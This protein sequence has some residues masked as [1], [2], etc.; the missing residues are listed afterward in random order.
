[1][2][3]QRCGSTQF[4]FD[5]DYEVMYCKSCGMIY[6]DVRPLFQWNILK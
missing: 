5:H 1:M 6:E 2:K 3:C 4:L